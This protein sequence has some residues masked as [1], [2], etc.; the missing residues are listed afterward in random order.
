MRAT[1]ASFAL[2]EYVVG[3]DRWQPTLIGPGTPDLGFLSPT[4]WHNDCR[5][6]TSHGL[7]ASR[8]KKGLKGRHV[9]DGFVVIRE[10]R[11]SLI[12]AAKPIAHQATGWSA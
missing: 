7:I 4:G 3:I 10:I 9:S 8:A 11:G 1:Y 6:S 5:G 2:L 12:S